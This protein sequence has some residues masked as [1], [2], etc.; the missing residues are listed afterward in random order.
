MIAFLGG[1]AMQHQVDH[2]HVDEILAG[3]GEEFIVL[4]EA[5][6]TTEPRERPLDDP[7]VR[8]KL[9]ALGRIAALDDFQIPPGELLDPLY[10]RSRVAAV[11]PEFFHPRT[12]EP[13]LLDH[14]LGSVAIL[15]V[16]GVNH[17]A[18]DQAE[19]VDNDVALAALDFLPRVVAP[20]LPPFSPVLADWLSMIAALGVLSRPSFSRNRSW[21]LS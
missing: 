16:G 17:H 15:H 10:Q 13:N 14:L 9:E 11:G 8:Q 19:R 1:Q 3:L 12:T 5:A 4:A 21:S 7:S 18:D 2:G 6:V 20:L